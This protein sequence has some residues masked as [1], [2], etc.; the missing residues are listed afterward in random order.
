MKRLVVMATLLA[1]AAVAPARAA[2]PELVVYAA[3]STVGAL[4]AM[5]KRYSAETGQPVRMVN[6]PAG[7]LAKRIEAGEHA[8]LF[9]S[10]NMAHPER[11]TREGKA[12]PTRLFARNALCIAARPDVHL[13][14]ADMLDRMLDPAIR[15][16]TSTPGADP[17]GDYAWAL[18]DRAGTVHPGA[19][20]ILKA[21]ALQL[22][23]DG[24]APAGVPKGTDAVRYFLDSH[25]VD[26]FVGYCS[27]HDLHPTPGLDRVRVPQSLAVPVEYG[28]VVMNDTDADRRGRADQLRTFLT[29]RAAQSLLPAYGF[30]SVTN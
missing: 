4:G 3:G 8:D 6:G 29:S 26:M 28:M 10:A 17:G 30:R 14:P 9:V 24:S 13:T 11:L 15:I 20:A 23:G 21:K 1:A 7:L 27:S 19:A 18:F 2:A 16:G 5:L 12:G 25:R 22:V